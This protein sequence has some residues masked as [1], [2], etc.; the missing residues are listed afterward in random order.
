MKKILFVMMMLMMAT[1]AVIAQ[2]SPTQSTEGGNNATLLQASGDYLYFGNQVMTKKECVQFLATRD[3]ASYEKFKSGYQC[4]NAGWWL[5]G[6]GLGLD[7]V[8]SVLLALIPA[9]GNGDAMFYSG[10]ACIG[11]GATAIIASIPTIFVGYSRL[12]KG[13]NMFNKS[14]AASVPQAYWTIQGSRDGIGVALHF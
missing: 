4:Y 8:G 1:M 12:N 7:L 6:G 11:L 10:C 3:Q 13:I 14:Q 5:L 9:D 2:D